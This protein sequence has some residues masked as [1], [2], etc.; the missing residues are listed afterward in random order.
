MPLDIP[1]LVAGLTLAEKAALTSGADFWFTEPVERLG[2]PSVMLTDG[3]HGLRKQ[4][5]DTATVGLTTSVPATCFP[6]A[7]ALASSWDR[8]LLRRVGRAL[9][10][11]ARAEGVAVLLGPGINIKRSPL[12]GRNFE[13]FSEDPLLA[14]ELAAAMV[15]GVQSQGVG[16]SLKHYAANNQ[17]TDRMRISA[18]VD[19]RTLREIYLPA[20]ERVVRQAR[21]WTVMAAYNRVNEVYAS[22]HRELLTD[23]LR[24]EWGFD[25]VVVSDWGAVD[26]RVPA[27]AAGLDLE[28]PAS[29][30][31]T[32]AEIVEAVETGL[33]DEKVLDQAVGRVLTLLD[34]VLPA[35]ADPGGYDRGAHHALA[36]EA[37]A[38]GTV[39][40][41]NDGLL[42][43]T[44][45]PGDT[46][47]VIGEFARTPRYQGAGSSLVHPT[48]L[49]DALSALRAAVPAGVDVRFAPGFTLPAGFG[50]DDGPHGA[51]EATRLRA[52][53]VQVAAAATSVL[54]FLGVPAAQES[55]GADR[56]HLDL[57]AEQLRLLEEVAAATPR[58]A[59]VLANGSVVTTGWSG[60]AAA[61]MEC[62]L[63]GQ[64]AGSAVA[65]VVLGRVDPSGRLA[66]TI[67]L[68]LADTPAYLHWPGE[69]GHARYG[70]GVFVGYRYYD[71]VGRDVAFP[72]GHGLSYTT[73]GYTDLSVAAAAGGGLNV[74]VTVTNTGSRAG[75]EVVQVYLSD[76][77]ASVA[78]PVRELAG[79]DTVDLAPGESRRVTVPVERRRL[80]FW[81]VRA[82]AWVVE[83]G[84]VEVA[85]GASSRDLRLRAIVE[86]TGD[87]VRFPLTTSS[88]L[89]EWL[90]DP[91]GGPRLRRLLGV[92]DGVPPSDVF[93][94]PELWVMIRAMPLRKLAT[95]GL[96]PAAVQDLVRQPPSG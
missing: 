62:W 33:L 19:E 3:P 63:G 81:S 38:A 89:E 12:C 17:E 4:A 91:D 73:F 24:A 57:P 82:H 47:A 29:G 53:A 58:V 34:R 48:R 95:F 31:A 71:T 46:I 2:I 6:T 67:P 78:R 1:A 84:S 18:D 56:T 66:E 79:F 76:L 92:P 28:M 11:E 55:E 94:G 45:H 7:A 22:Q 39:L 70:E 32:D 59:V 51:A 52:E 36:R 61:V 26:E 65:D 21:P 72:F 23:I 20:F 37:A 74:T 43:L 30:G 68:R 90:A 5:T 13:Y 87:D 40:L 80:A 10:A 42:P 41:C 9:G 93:G 25:G 83:S 60:R 49:D 85:V 88:T 64:G 16:T 44:P 69:E 75:R 15:E 27:L 77:A 96:D 54:L 8:D 86:V 14:G 50:G 35:L